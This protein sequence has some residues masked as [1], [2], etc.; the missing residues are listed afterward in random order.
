MR[1]ARM[2]NV[3]V[4][5]E[6]GNVDIVFKNTAYSKLTIQLLPVRGSR[7]MTN[8]RVAVLPLGSDLGA[9]LDYRIRGSGTNFSVDHIAQGDYVLVAM[10]DFQEPY[11]ET[12]TSIISDSYPVRIHDDTNVTIPVLE[13]VDIPGQVAPAGG[14][15]SGTKVRLQ[16]VDTD[17]TQTFS[18]DV[19]SAGRFTLADVG[20]GTYDVYV[21][22]LSQAFYLRAVSPASDSREIGR[23]RIDNG[24]PRYFDQRSLRWLLASSMLISIGRDSGTLS[25]NVTGSGKPVPG[26]LVVRVP[27]DPQARIRVDR[28]LTTYSAADGAFQIQNIPPGRYTAFSFERIEDDIYFD[29]DFNTQ[30]ASLGR[31]MT[32]SPGEKKLQD[33][34][35]ITVEEL[36]RVVR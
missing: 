22:G 19:D 2:V 20:I 23:I 15:D 33:L 31:A 16:R 11:G 34:D 30:V 18:A 25:G 13:P 27:D 29:A 26:A 8:S 7:A 21:E 32:V 35:F 4:G 28:Y 1:D 6:T 14:L 12:R 10:A 9:A 5:R 24:K 17:V 36:A 3:A